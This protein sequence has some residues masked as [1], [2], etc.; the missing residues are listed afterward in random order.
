M[1]PRTVSFRSLADLRTAR[2]MAILIVTRW[3]QFFSDAIILHKCTPSKHILAWSYH[4]QNVGYV[5]TV[6]PASVTG[7]LIPPGEY[8]S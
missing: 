2:T 7:N 1:L 3:L 8:D 6:T 4:R 5:F